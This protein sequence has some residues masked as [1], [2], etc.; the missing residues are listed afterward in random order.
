MINLKTVPIAVYVILGMLILGIF[1]YFIFK[2]PKKV[3]DEEIKEGT[4]NEI[5]EIK[6]SNPSI[7]QTYSNITYVQWADQIYHAVSGAG[8][9]E[10]SIFQVFY[11]LKNKLDWAML[12]KAFGVRDE[13]SL[14]AWLR[15]DLKVSL[16]NKLN[17]EL[18]R[19]NVK[20]RI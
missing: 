11:Q 10:D 18:R 17:N 3:T 14:N 13:M 5:D 15:D 12:K 6:E 20:E 7:K 8:T 4:Q 9:N 16:I 1:V 2:E 19:I